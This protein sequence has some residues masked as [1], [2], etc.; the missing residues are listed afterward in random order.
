MYVLVG[1]PDNCK[2]SKFDCNELE[3][4]EMDCKPHS[5]LSFVHMSTRYLKKIG[6]SGLPTGIQGATEPLQSQDNNH[7]S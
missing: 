7:C 4:G 6:F 3:S 1:F 5:L 2:E